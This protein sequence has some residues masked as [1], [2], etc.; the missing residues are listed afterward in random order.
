MLTYIQSGSNTYTLRT[1]PTGSSNVFTMSLQ[2]MTTLDNSNASLSNVTFEPYESIL[3]FTAS[4]S[5]TYKSEEYRATIYNGT[6]DI[7]HG[8]LQ[9]L[10]SQSWEDN[11]KSDYRNQIP[12]DDK[13]V[14]NVS[15]NK[16]IIYK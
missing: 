8:S 10:V 11:S 15:Q 16:Y 3:A 1:K 4:I 2:N 7:W 5:N 14:S 13:F 9:V 12:L 6:T